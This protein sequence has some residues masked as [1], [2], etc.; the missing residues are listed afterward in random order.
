MKLILLATILFLSGCVPMSDAVLN[1]NDTWPAPCYVC[2]AAEFNAFENQ[3]TN[4]RNWAIITG[5][6]GGVIQP[7]SDSVEMV[8]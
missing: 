7:Y 5:S 6:Q 3:A 4:E 2:S 8:P 1:M